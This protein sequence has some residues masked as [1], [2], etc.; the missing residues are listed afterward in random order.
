MPWVG[1]VVLNHDRHLD[2]IDHLTGKDTVLGDLVVAVCGDPNLAGSDEIDDSDKSLAHLLPA[3]VTSGLSR[4]NV[5]LSGGRP[6]PARWS[7]K[8]GKV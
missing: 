2:I 3:S 5:T 6:P 8:L 7:V 1:R 4:A